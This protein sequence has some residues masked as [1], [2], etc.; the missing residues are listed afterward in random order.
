MRICKKPARP[1]DNDNDKNNNVDRGD[2]IEEGK[3]EKE[4]GGTTSNAL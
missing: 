2:R 3:G 4:T 1:N